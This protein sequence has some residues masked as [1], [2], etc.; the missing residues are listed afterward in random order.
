M[1]R[2]TTCPGRAKRLGRKITGSV[3]RRPLLIAGA[4]AVYIVTP[5]LAVPAELLNRSA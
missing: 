5:A 2:Y 3:G 1:L 4:L